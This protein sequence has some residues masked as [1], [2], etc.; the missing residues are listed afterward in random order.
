MA[1]NSEGDE[2]AVATVGAAQPQKA[3]RKDAAF[4]KGVELILDELRQVSAGRVLHMREAGLDM[5][6]H[7]PV[8]G[9]LLRAAAFVL[10][11][12]SIGSLLEP[13]SSGWHALLAF[14][15][16]NFMVR[17]GKARLNRR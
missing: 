13:S 7:H 15:P 5:I 3:K 16:R 11:P 8:Q 17:R 4:E 9:S 6:L 10:N 14:G 1:G 2:L 12:G